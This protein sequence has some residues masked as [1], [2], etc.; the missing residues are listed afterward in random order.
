MCVAGDTCRAKGIQCFGLNVVHL[1]SC[2][3][4]AV[5]CCAGCTGSVEEEEAAEPS[6]QRGGLGFWWKSMNPKLNASRH[7]HMGKN[8]R[9]EGLSPNVSYLQLTIF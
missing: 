4:L 3:L 8:S 6:S 9:V 5:R 1:R 2:F 7:I